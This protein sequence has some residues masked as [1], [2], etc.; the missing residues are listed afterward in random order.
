MIKGISLVR[1]SLIFSFSKEVNTS[2]VSSSFKDNSSSLVP[3]CSNVSLLVDVSI[4]LSSVS[5]DNDS[6]SISICFNL[7]FLGVL[8]GLFLTTFSST[9]G[10][11]FFLLLFFF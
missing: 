9:L 6:S 11:T 5:S 2:D 10:E 8:L 4:L 3:S 1:S 7:L